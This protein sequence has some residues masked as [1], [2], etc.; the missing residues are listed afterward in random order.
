MLSHTDGY[1]AL[2]LAMGHKLPLL[3]ALQED[4]TAVAFAPSAGAAP[5]EPG[6]PSK[7]AVA[8][9]L[10]CHF[11]FSDRMKAASEWM[12]VL[13]GFNWTLQDAKSGDS[14]PEELIKRY[15]PWAVAP[16]KVR[17]A[18]D[19][20]IGEYPEVAALMADIDTPREEGPLSSRGR[21]R[22]TLSEME[23]PLENVICYKNI[24]H[25]KKDAAGNI[26]LS[27]LKGAP[28]SF[29]MIATVK[30]RLVKALIARMV[31]LSA[32]ET[33][34]TA[35]LSGAPRGTRELLDWARDETR[36]KDGPAVL[37]YV[38]EQ[39]LDMLA[40][41]IAAVFTS[42]YMTVGADVRGAKVCPSQ[43]FP[44]ACRLLREI[45]CEGTS[46]GKKAWGRTVQIF[47]FSESRRMASAAEIVTAVSGQ[48]RPSPLLVVSGGDALQEPFWPEGLGVN[49]G[50][51]NVQDSVWAINQWQHVRGNADGQQRV[52]EERQKLYEAFSLL[53]SGN[54]KRVLQG[55]D[56]RTNSMLPGKERVYQRT[57]VD[58][59]T[60]YNTEAFKFVPLKVRPD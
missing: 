10:V 46:Y 25:D 57:T 42:H 35:S 56:P 3:R 53:M 55:Y 5:F 6:E 48:P 22:G 52:V 60:R 44:E 11:E 45:P 38:F 29:Y 58:P 23:A 31:L 21:R 16:I 43:P 30:P 13:D 33:G 14:D 54:N 34:A 24:A 32:R 2:V 26:E 51:N 18:L 15:G 28:P 12:H 7:N 20:F 8:T 50:V 41:A 36:K 1:D 37:A 9:A 40:K 49:R 47:D 4:A 19:E 27:N 17:L 39:Q 59:C